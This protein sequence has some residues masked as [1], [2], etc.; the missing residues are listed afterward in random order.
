MV[1]PAVSKRFTEINILSEKTIVNKC[2]KNLQK[3]IEH[4]IAIWARL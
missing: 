2:R 3:G 1:Y 4:M